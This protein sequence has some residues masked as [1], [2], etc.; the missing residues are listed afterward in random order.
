MEQLRRELVYFPSSLWRT[1][2]GRLIGSLCRVDIAA[3]KNHRFFF[4]REV[5]LQCCEFKS[6]TKQLNKQLN[7]KFAF[8]L[9]E[10]R[11][12]LFAPSELNT[13]GNALARWKQL[14]VQ[15]TED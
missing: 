8:S 12:S 1:G 14:V 9:R 10:T 13:P 6:E 11:R 5:C 7:S 15:A 3:T 4:S 2:S